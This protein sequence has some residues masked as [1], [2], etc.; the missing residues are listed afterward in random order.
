MAA[1]QAPGPWTRRKAP[2]NQ[3]V[4]DH[5]LLVNDRLTKGYLQGDCSMRLRMSISAL[6]LLAMCTGQ[7]FA[8]CNPNTSLAGRSITCCGG[9]RSIVQIC[10]TGGSIKGCNPTAHK[11][12]CG[13]CMINQ[14]AGCKVASSKPVPLIDKDEPNFLAHDLAPA[15]SGCGTG[16]EEWVSGHQHT[17]A[18]LEPSKSQTAG[19]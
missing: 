12:L 10:T 11:I 9:D 3:P 6:A 5:K 14:A 19:F 8:Q 7:G 15:P 13:A 17:K 16:L 1:A 2:N 4:L 18:K